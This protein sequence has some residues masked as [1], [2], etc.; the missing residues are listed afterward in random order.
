MDSHSL[1]AIEQAAFD[2]WPALEETDLAGWRLRCADG[3]TKRAN[4]ANAIGAMSELSLRQIESIESFYRD[5]GLNTVFRLASFCTSQAVDDVLTDRGYR[6]ADMSLVMT[7][8]LPA[9]A[10]LAP[11]AD[12]PQATTDIEAWL[13]DYQTITGSERSPN[14]A[15]RRLLHSIRGETRFLVTRMDGHPV[16]CGL[17]VKSGDSLG[18]F[19][20]A[21]RPENRGGGLASALCREVLRWGTLRGA[22]TAFLQVEADNHAA[23]HIYETLGYRRRYHYWYRIS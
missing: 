17:G 21:T 14:P 16:S 13:D 23:V 11:P 15:H 8:A 2:A 20:V 5:R 18:L 7:L 12:G 1:H 9:Q 22:R 19:Q 4:S 6:Y 3:Y 10:Q